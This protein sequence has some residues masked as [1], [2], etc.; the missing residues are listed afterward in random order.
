MR[1]FFRLQRGKKPETPE[2]LLGFRA[3]SDVKASQHADGI[4]LISHN[5]SVVFSANR[6]G[7]MIW[8]AI[9]ERGTLG[10]LSESISRE[11]QVAPE[12]ARQDVL[13]FL[14]QLAAEGLLVPAS[15]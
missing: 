6:T 15:S 4:V 7:A 5:R 11:F 8:S 10:G 3:A 9:V 12:T 1:G 14:G 2:G 13:E